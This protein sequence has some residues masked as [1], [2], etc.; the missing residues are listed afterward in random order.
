[1]VPKTRCPVS[2]ACMA[3]LKVSW[4][5][6]SPTRMMSGSCRT[7]SFRALCKSM[8]SMPTSRWLKID[9]SSLK[10][11][12]IGSSMVTMCIRSRSLMYWSIEAI[13]VL[14]P[15]PVT[16]ARMMIPCSYWVISA[17]TGGQA[18]ALEVG[19]LVVHAP[20][21]QAESAAGP[22]QVDAEPGLA[23]QFPVVDDVREVDPAFFF[24]DL[25]LPG[26]EE[27]EHQPFHVGRSRAA[28]SASGGARRPDAWPE[29][30][31]PSDGGRTP[32][33]S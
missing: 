14:L 2:A 16:P 20:G 19:D 15:Y 27:R 21:D 23:V 5:R 22:E 7:A 6:I 24:E 1:M 17:M 30:G 9:L 18:Q 8:T 28:A 33:A 31:R 13:V 3:A 25:L 29:A 10:V 26:R 11:N 32:R 4:S 12:S